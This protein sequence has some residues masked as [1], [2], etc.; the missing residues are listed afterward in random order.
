MITEQSIR[1]ILA[2][3]EKHLWILRR[4]LFSE[5][6]TTALADKQ[7]SLFGGVSVV[8]SAIDALWFS[9]VS[10]PDTESWEIRHLSETPFALVEVA[11]SGMSEDE[12]DEMLRT[13]ELKMA[14]M[15]KA[16]SIKSN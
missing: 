2:L 10:K 15:I 4:V 8:P 13:A 7:E 11:D 16:R 12:R 5:D 14:D 9:R 3:Y 1:E 6:S